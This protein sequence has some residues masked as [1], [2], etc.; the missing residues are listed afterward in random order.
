MAYQNSL[1]NTQHS[2]SFFCKIIDNSLGNDSRY[3][4]LLEIIKEY[5][6]TNYAFYSDNIILKNNFF[7]PLFHTMYLGNGNH[8]VVLSDEDDIWLTDIFTNNKYYILKTN[9]L[10]DTI[11]N[12]NK[13]QIISHLK[14]IL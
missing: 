8:N 6:L 11:I 4:Q 7:I 9:S 5:P 10:H 14:E 12:N 1:I 13:I 3:I 2:I